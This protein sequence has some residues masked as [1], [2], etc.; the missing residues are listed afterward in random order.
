MITLYMCLNM[1]GQFLTPIILMVI[2]N[3]DANEFRI[4]IYTQWAFLA[5]MLPIF[6]WLPESPAYFVAKDQDAAARHVLTRVNGNVAGYDVE[7]ELAIIKN[8]IAEERA[9]NAQLGIGD[10]WRSILRSYA[11]CVKGT[12]GR[13]TLAA[14]LPASAGQLTGLSFLAT[15]SSRAFFRACPR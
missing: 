12:N 3:G 8:T 1:V 13:R 14:A 5:I 15:Y 11:E 4:P 7:R 9:I 10:D 2:K 6:L